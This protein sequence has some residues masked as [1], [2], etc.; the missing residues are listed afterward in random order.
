MKS[1]L[2]QAALTG[3]IIWGATIFLTTLLNLY[4]GYGTDF[5]KIWISIYPGYSLTM[6]GSLVGLVYGFFDMFIGV[7][8]I[9]WVYLWL[10]RYVK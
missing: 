7:Y 8:I 2:L 9:Y 1:K 3:G 4:T 5:L 6:V 10:G